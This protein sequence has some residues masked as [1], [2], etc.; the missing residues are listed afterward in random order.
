MKPQ[1]AFIDKQTVDRFLLAVKIFASSEEGWMAKIM[2]AGLIALLL[3]VNGMNVLNNYVGRDFMTSIEHR[4]KDGFVRMALFYFVV[5]AG[6]TLVSVFA[7]VI[8]D[9]LG[10]LWR[11][12]ITKRV[13]GLYLAQGTYYRL[14]HNG[15]LENPDQRIAE[16]L[17]A[18]TA[19]TLSFVVMLLNSS[20]TIVAFSGVVWS[21]SPAL[22]AVAL[23]YAA[24]GSY[25]AI[26]LGRPLVALN[27]NQLDKDANF[28][29]TLI[30]VRE[31]AEPLFL[32]HREGRLAKRLLSL[33]DEVASNIRST[34]NL[35]RNLG[36]FTGGYYWLI[37]LIPALIVAPSFMDGKIEFGVVTQ[38]AMAFSTLVGAFSLIVSQ[39]QSISTFTAVVS[40]LESLV[41]AIEEKPLESEVV[42]QIREEK[43]RIAFE[44]LTLLSPESGEFLLKDLSISIPCGTRV[45]ITGANEAANKSLF[46]AITGLSVNGSGQI[47]RPNADEILFLARRP[48]MLPGTLRELLVPSLLEGEISDEHLI[49]LLGELDLEPVLARAGG[50]DEEQ[51]WDSILS[52]GEQELLALIHI[53]LSA[54]HFVFLDRPGTVLSPKQI[55]K[56]L[57]MFTAHS[58]SY[59]NSGKGNGTRVLYDA[60]LEIQE[61]GSWNWKTFKPLGE[62]A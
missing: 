38:S 1:E 56:I 24:C 29:S 15:V 30:H 53:L 5:F 4:D 44:G 17:R 62:G 10:L 52:L 9:R 57:K 36:F 8:E 26:W 19:T 21:I 61:D 60:V 32:A 37:G 40:R 3:G 43:E 46:K 34:I 14:E 22:F 54:P 16:D 35:N 55:K 39:F 2:F 7:K 50:L 58:I 47:V 33:F 20:L 49:S 11:A 59:I 42:I 41:E 6:S 31:N 13:I 25:F 18:F 48:Y 45:L 51:D 28:R 27:Y 12:L 23:A